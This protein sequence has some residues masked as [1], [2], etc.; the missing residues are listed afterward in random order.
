M[1]LD[2]LTKEILTVLGLD[3]DNVIFGLKAKDIIKLALTKQL[4]DTISVSKINKIRK[5][6][7]FKL[8][9]DIVGNTARFNRALES[10]TNYQ[11]CTECSQVV[12]KD[13]FSKASNR[14]TGL[15]AECNDCRSSIGKT[16]RS[17]NLVYYRFKGNEYRKNHLSSYAFREARR[18][19]T[20]YNATPSWANSFKINEIYNNRPEGYHVDHIVPLSN[21]KV[22]GLHCEYNLQYLPVLENIRKNNT[23][24]IE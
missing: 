1:D 22:C 12:H 18:R 19:A 10:L 8:L 2:T 6:N 21:S 3:A 23:F 13:K 14:T 16:R 5:S 9:F 17:N 15:V 20:K 4:R 11:I 24:N 7:E